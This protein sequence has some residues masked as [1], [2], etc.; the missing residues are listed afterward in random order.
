MKPKDAIRTILCRNGS[1]FS[2]YPEKTPA[3]NSAGVF[4][5]LHDKST[6]AVLCPLFPIL[7]LFIAQ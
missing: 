7:T 1:D 6:L 5:W 3:E 2:V 4:L